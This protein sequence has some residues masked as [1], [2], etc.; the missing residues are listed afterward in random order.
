MLNF[1]VK[2]Q[3]SF[4]KY[5]QKTIREMKGQHDSNQQS[6]TLKDMESQKEVN[7]MPG[8]GS[9]GTETGN[10]HQPSTEM[11]DGKDKTVSPKSFTLRC[12]RG[13]R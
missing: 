13:K 5:V 11:Q 6:K 4:S 10:S 2:K 3:S 7:R 8:V 1:A 9:A 12:S